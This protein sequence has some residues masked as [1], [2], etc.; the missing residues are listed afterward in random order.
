MRVNID[1]DTYDVS[2]IHRRTDLWKVIT[3]EERRGRAI[4][5]PPDIYD[6]NIGRKV[7]NGQSH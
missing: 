4:C 6:K 3:G 2:W 5:H 1:G 7:L